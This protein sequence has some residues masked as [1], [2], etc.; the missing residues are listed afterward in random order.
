M[1]DQ[2]EAEAE[3]EVGDAVEISGGIG[4]LNL[5]YPPSHNWIEMLHRP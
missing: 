2:E 4:S 3:S 5:R 1:S